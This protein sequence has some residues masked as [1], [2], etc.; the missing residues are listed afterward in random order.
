MEDESDPRPPGAR[1][2]N[3]PM[4]WWTPDGKMS[5]NHPALIRVAARLRRVLV[6]AQA[7]G[8]WPFPDTPAVPRPDDAAQ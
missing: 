7:E 6:R 2:E 8:R 4:S 3:E 1:A 5:V